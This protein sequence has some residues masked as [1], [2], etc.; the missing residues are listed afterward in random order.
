MREEGLPQERSSGP[1]GLVVA[2]DT[3]ARQ[4]SL[5]LGSF[6][7]GGKRMELL[8]SRRIDI[9]EEH[10]SLLVPRIEELL[11]E[12][13]SGWSELRGV[14]AGA[15]PG[16]F[17]GVRVG[18]ATAKGMAWALGLPLWAVSS[19]VGAAAALEEEPL[20]PR[21]VLFD[22]R[23]DRLYVG[24]FR[25]GDRQVETL[26]SPMATTVDRVLEDLV[27]PGSVLMG[28]GA[29][30]H[31][32][33]LGSLGVPILPSPAGNPSAPGLLRSLAL[34]PANPPVDDLA[35][36]GPE[37]LRASGAERAGATRAVDR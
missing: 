37:Y 15:G 18:A 5:A 10:A 6:A 7:A 1:S 32:D 33:L 20:K 14:V 36:W 27:P 12:V 9:E 25:F 29:W 11:A 16:S 34:E 28:D 22:A 31:R 8:A 35:R 13:E 30:R 23:A 19:L 4:G 2:L 26:V 21:M 17:T 3:S 24:A